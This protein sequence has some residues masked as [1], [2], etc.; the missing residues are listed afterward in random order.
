MWSLVG[1]CMQVWK[2]KVSL[3]CCL[4][5][6]HHR[7]DERGLLSWRNNPVCVG[8]SDTPACWTSRHSQGSKAE[9]CWPENGSDSLDLE[10][11]R[12]SLLCGKSVVVACAGSVDT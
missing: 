8:G 5:E 11:L 12:P 7:G 1:Y 6:P 10:G 2:E 9:K 3:A 4:R